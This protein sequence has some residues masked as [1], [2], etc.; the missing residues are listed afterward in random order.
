[1]VNMILFQIALLVAIRLDVNVAT[2][3]VNLRGVI[4]QKKQLKFGIGG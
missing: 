2:H 3:I 1:M 4:V